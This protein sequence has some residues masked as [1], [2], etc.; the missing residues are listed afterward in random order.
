[1]AGEDKVVH[2]TAELWAGEFGN[3]YI[4]RNSNVPDRSEFWNRMMRRYKPESVL[5]VGCN[6]GHNLRYIKAAVPKA[7]IYG[8]DVNEEA[9]AILRATQPGIFIERAEA[10]DLPYDDHTVDMVVSVGL[11]IHLTD[12]ASLETAIREMFRVAKKHVLIAEYWAPEWTPIP[13]HGYVNALR[14]GPFDRVVKEVMGKH[15]WWSGRL[16]AKDGFDRVHFWLY[17]V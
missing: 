14:K 13:Y 5:E 1:M 2:N 9:L 7:S 15:Y 8:V 11:L 12:D 17:Q 6:I 4:K 10:T 3:E 16:E